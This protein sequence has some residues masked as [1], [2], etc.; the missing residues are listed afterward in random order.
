[1]ALAFKP[2]A[3]P[4]WVQGAALLAALAGLATWSVVLSA[5]TGQTGQAALVQAVPA[6][7]AA[8]RQWFANLPAQIDIS[9]SGLL[10]GSAGAV[11]IVSLNGAAPQAVRVGEQLAQGVR[12]VAIEA[13][14]LVLERAGERSRIS[15]ARLPEG[16]ALPRLTRP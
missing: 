11:A 10:A 15:M 12:L 14:A 8:A 3:A 16:P 1:M 7:P 4:Q 6:P 9:L 13:D 2:V 5:P